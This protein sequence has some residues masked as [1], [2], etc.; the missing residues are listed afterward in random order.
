VLVFEGPTN[1]GPALHP[2]HPCLLWC[3]HRSGEDLVDDLIGCS[4][5]DRRGVLGS[6]ALPTGWCQGAPKNRRLV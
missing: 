4:G 2:T 5:L 6:Q 1:L 3:E